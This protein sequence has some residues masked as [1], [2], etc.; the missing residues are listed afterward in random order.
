[1]LNPPRREMILR[2]SDGICFL[3]ISPWWHRMAAFALATFVAAGGVLGWQYSRVSHRLAVND[4]EIV[5]VADAYQ[6]TIDHLQTSIAQLETTVTGVQQ[7]ATRAQEAA[8]AETE[9]RQAA[10]AAMNAENEALRQRLETLRTEMQ[11]A[12]AEAEA[13]AARTRMPVVIRGGDRSAELQDALVDRLRVL[14]TQMRTIGRGNAQVSGAAATLQRHIED[15]EATRREIASRAQGAIEVQNGVR[16]V[17]GLP[18]AEILQ[19]T[20]PAAGRISSDDDIGVLIPPLD[21]E[22]D[23]DAARNRAHLGVQVL[24][25]LVRRTGINPDRALALGGASYEVGGPFV[26]LRSRALT[27]LRAMQSE[28]MHYGATAGRLADLT[29]LVR[30]MPLGKP[31]PDYEVTSGFGQRSDPFNGQP[32]MHNGVDLRAAAGTPVQTTASGVV[33]IAEVHGEFGNLVEISHGFGLRTR[34]GHLSRT[35][36]TAGD[37][38]EAGQI[39]GAVG[40][41]GRSTGPHLHYEIL[42]Q[43][44]N[45]DPLKFLEVSRHV[46]ANVQRRFE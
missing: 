36:V 24:S 20:A 11:T 28:L 27:D 13:E 25:G 17:P 35:D 9:R 34:Y 18:P 21:G 46:L 33:T 41:T 12:R 2:T 37:R 44:G 29:R 19:G 10:L 8:R 40:S 5:Q 42:F 6:S 38:V 3:T 16:I 14:E 31:L 30:S 22:P 15:I 23:L 45:L 39:L 43:Q 32:A 26:P 1:M 7:D 4:V